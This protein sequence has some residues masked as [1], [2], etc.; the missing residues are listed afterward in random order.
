M[1]QDE[2]KNI[3]SFKP[4]EKESREVEAVE[5]EQKKQ[6]IERLRQEL[7][8]IEKELD[9]TREARVESF[10]K[11][12]IESREGK[13]AVEKYEP[14]SV[15]Q[16]QIAQQ[17]QVIKHLDPQNQVKTLCDLAFQKGLDIAIRAA[18]ELN[19]A[20]VLDAFHDTLVDKLYE[21]LKKE[22]KIKEI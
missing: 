9:K 19:N 7:T 16:I 8:R 1:Q 17:A 12:G 18:R 2:Q 21:Q 13:E 11:T 15:P 14:A 10:E 20:Y 4:D 3:P 5:V 22:G 6:E